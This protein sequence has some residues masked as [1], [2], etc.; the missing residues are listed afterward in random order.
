MLCYAMLCYVILC[1][2]LCS[3]H[4][5]NALLFCRSKKNFTITCTPQCPRKYCYFIAFKIVLS[6][7]MNGDRKLIFYIFKGK[8]LKTMQ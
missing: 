3:A 1:Y 5:Q 4:I 6:K 8:Y 7:I 2:A